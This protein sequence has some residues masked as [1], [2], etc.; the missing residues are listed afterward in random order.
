[1]ITQI[2][3]SGRNSPIL[4]ENIFVNPQSS[5]KQ[6]ISSK[7]ICKTLHNTDKKLNTTVINTLKDWKEIAAHRFISCKKEFALTAKYKVDN[8]T[9]SV[10]QYYDVLN[11][12][13]ECLTELSNPDKNTTA[14]KILLLYK[15][16]ILQG[17]SCIVLENDHVYVKGLVSAPWNIPMNGPIQQAHQSLKVKGVGTS[18]L[19]DIYTTAQ[20]ERKNSIVLVSLPGS[21]SFYK[22]HIGM[23]LMDD[24]EEDH[25]FHGLQSQSKFELTVSPYEVPKQLQD[26]S[27]GLLEKNH[28]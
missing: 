12:S 25:P 16:T 15:D 14:L 10:K 27:S 28:K 7:F 17:I 13:T 1:M 3:N 19:R 2:I 5:T 23:K 8:D 4:I 11:L 9:E 22:D 26:K 6:I 21:Y 24:Y 18:L 20:E